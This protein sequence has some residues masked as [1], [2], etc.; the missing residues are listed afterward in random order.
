MPADDVP[1]D[2][3]PDDGVDLVAP[4]LIL[5]TELAPRDERY[6]YT[7]ADI[8][9]TPRSVVFGTLGN[10]GRSLM[11]VPDVSSATADPILPAPTTAILRM[12]LSLPDA[13]PQGQGESR[14]SQLPFRRKSTI[15]S[16]LCRNLWAK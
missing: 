16:A 9:T 11:Y 4:D 7:F 15:V 12:T 6:S 2:L 3:V 14:R 8:G 10:D 5:Q 1:G 13:P